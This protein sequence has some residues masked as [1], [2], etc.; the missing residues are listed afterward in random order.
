MMIEPFTSLSLSLVKIAETQTARRRP[1]FVVAWEDALYDLA[2]MADPA[3]LTAVRVAETVIAL[4]DAREAALTEVTQLAALGQHLANHAADQA[5]FY[6]RVKQLD[7]VFRRLL[8]FDLALHEPSLQVSEIALNEP[9]LLDYIQEWRLPETTSTPA[10]VLVG[11]VPR[12]LPR[13]GIEFHRRTPRIL[14]TGNL[15][16]EYAAA[17]PFPFLTLAGRYCEVVASGERT[18]NLSNYA[19]QDTSPYDL[20]V[21]DRHNNLLGYVRTRTQMWAETLCAGPLTVALP[22]LEP[23]S[24]VTTSV[25][26]CSGRVVAL[27]YRVYPTGNTCPII[28]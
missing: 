27:C 23:Q 24:V 18:L 9:R 16:I 11:R 2:E 21:E 20:A 8:A 22:P 13:L 3:T 25:E 14:E 10:V 1:A 7:Q 15:L 12:R 5:A 17:T 6:E 28:A 26:D 4:A 19:Q